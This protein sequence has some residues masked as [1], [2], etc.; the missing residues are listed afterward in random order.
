MM[1][2]EKL[3]TDIDTCNSFIAPA[4]CNVDQLALFSKHLVALQESSGQESV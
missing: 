3:S 1:N 2:V 4:P